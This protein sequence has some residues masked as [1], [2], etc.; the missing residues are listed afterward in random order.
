[1]LKRT[2]YSIHRVL[3]TILSILFL[4]WFLSGFVMIY[5]KFPKATDIDKRSH[6]DVLPEGIVPINSLLQSYQITPDSI[7]GCKLTSFANN[8]YFEVTMS[9]T[10]LR[11]PA[12]AN[13]SILPP[14]TYQQIENYAHRW[15]EADIIHTDTLR[16]LE[17]WIPF[18]RLRDE[19]PI[20][21]FYF[22]DSQEHQLY[23]SSKTGEALQFT[24]KDNRFWAWLG[25]IPHWIYF[26]SL[27][28]DAQLWMDVVIWISGL[29]CIMCL[30]GM[31][32]GIRAYIIRYRRYKKLQSAYKKLMYKWHHILGFFFGI[33]VFTFIF[34]GMMSLAKVPKWMVKVHDVNIEAKLHESKPIDFSSYTLGIQDIFGQ[35]P[36][37]VKSIEW[38]SF[39]N[40][41][42]Y[43][44]VAGN[45]I[46]SIDASSSIPSA[47]NL[48]E[49]DIM[50]HL[51]PIHEGYEMKIMQMDEYDNYYVG[52]SD[53]L[54]LPVYKVSVGDTDGSTYYINPKK[55]SILYF[56]NNTKI[57]KWSYQ[58]LH[59]FKIK[60]L[61]EHPVLWNIVMFTTMIGGTLVSVTGVWLG[62][63]YIRRK[64]RQL[65][66][67]L[68]RKQ[69]NKNVC[70]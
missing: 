48:N 3:G 5:H 7:L 26:T 18:G 58:A 38:S 33:F 63:K 59:S 24:N 23:V 67:Y 49:V 22:D 55:G 54:P 60:Y 37:Q 15:N 12:Q 41:P 64:L 70:K 45:K 51:R 50:N 29:G 42:F 27:R 62:F 21:K 14:I 34:S 28:Q 56:N 57:R 8:P 35:Y 25:A 30:T 43:K 6:M 13:K 9:D 17:Q 53:H 31:I 52:L 46:L 10:V 47:L 61:A 16:N 36:G 19:F 68:W 40:V 1:M 4:M 2:L 32:L 39:G 66:K 11:I 65:K 44:V 20:Y 69:K